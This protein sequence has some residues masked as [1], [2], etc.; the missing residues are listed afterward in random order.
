[1]LSC[2]LKIF[3]PS[4]NDIKKVVAVKTALMGDHDGLRRMM[5]EYAAM[6]GVVRPADLQELG[7][8]RIAFSQLFRQH[9]GREDAMVQ[10]VRL[11]GVGLAG[12]RIMQEHR[13]RV[14]ALFLRYSDHIKQWTPDQIDRDWGAYRS[15]VLALQQ[16]L[17]AL[18]EWEER[19]LHPL[20][21]G[22]KAA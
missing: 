19:Y 1:M 8:R 14:M 2:N 5:R 15:A 13:D 9:M 3:V 21:A 20:A 22:L 6:M 16:S 18:M 10:A 4:C 17:W 7:R 12:E 11:S